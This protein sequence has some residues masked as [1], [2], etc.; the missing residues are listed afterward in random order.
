MTRAAL[1]SA[2]SLQLAVEPSQLQ[3]DSA[4][5]SQL[6]DVETKRHLLTLTKTWCAY[7]CIV[8]LLMLLDMKPHVPESTTLEQNLRSGTL[9]MA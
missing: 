1:P 4:E 7:V 6:A 8:L 3:A 2:T 5:S 9:R